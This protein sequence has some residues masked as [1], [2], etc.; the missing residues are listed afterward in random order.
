MCSA[1][2]SHTYE[3]PHLKCQESQE[4]AKRVPLG[5]QH[6]TDSRSETASVWCMTGCAFLSLGNILYCIRP[7]VTPAWL[8]YTQTRRDVTLCALS[9]CESDG[10]SW[11]NT[12]GGWSWPLS[13]VKG[14]QWGMRRCGGGGLWRSALLLTRG[15]EMWRLHLICAKQSYRAAFITHMII[16]DW[17]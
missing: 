3:S 11:A 4:G 17:Q 13:T 14:E 9:P 2:L 8:L 7:F 6:S 1:D 16:S 12:T 5:F 15:G 10:P